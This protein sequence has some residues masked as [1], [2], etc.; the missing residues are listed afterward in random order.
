MHG[1]PCPPAARS[2]QP[3]G[4]P[5]V[6]PRIAHRASRTAPAALRAPY[7][8]PM[9]SNSEVASHLYE[10]AK[11][12][13]LA[14]GS[15]NAFRVRAYE[16]AAR[17]VDALTE[18]V[19][20][21]PEAALTALRGVG[22]S[23]AK[24]I[25][26]LVDTGAIGKLA[27]LRGQFPPE[28]V[29]LTRVPGV[30]PKT[31]V[32]LRDRLGITG[33]AALRV[34]LEVHALRDLPGFGAKTEE[35]LLNALD[36][37]GVGGKE[38]RTPIIDAM[39]VARDVCGALRGVPGVKLAEPM[40]SLRR[41]R[42]TTGD[43]DVVVISTGD[44]EAVMAR[45]VELPVVR[46]VVGHGARKSAVVTTSGLQVDL[47]VVEPHQYGSA[48]LYFTGS[49][50]H[51]IRLR[52]MAIDRG[53]ILNEYAL[54]EADGT[55]IASR[56]EQE[57][58][59]ALG[60]PWIPPELREDTGEIEAALA[61]ALP[62]L[63][64]EKELRGDLHVHTSLSGDGRD[65]LSAMVAAAAKRGYRYMAITDHAEDLS[66]NG[67][68]REQL[69]AQRRSISRLQPKHPDLAILQGVELNIGKDGS[70]DYDPEFLDGFGFG[71]ASVHSHF[72]LPAAQQTERVI[73]AMRNRAVNVIGHLT[74]RMIG[75]RP[76]IDLDVDAI[77]VAA[78]ETG[79]ALEVNSH[80][81]RLDAPT[82][83]LR[84]AHD[85]PGVIF[86]ISTDSHGVGEL[87]D[88]TWGVHHARRGW[89]EKA[90]VANTWPQKKFLKWVGEKRKA[91]GEGR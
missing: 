39:R 11:L 81:D 76:G 82:E 13:T 15:S 73:A 61:G 69:L 23:T 29:E 26:E 43:V 57:V 66:I 75:K 33:V 47:R 71:V 2:L 44:P 31:A 62:D 35:N 65:P 27:E 87:A 7:P 3:A 68:T 22:P 17:T 51:N 89:V 54:A 34:A 37:L 10:L 48:A 59:G 1:R 45:F 5:A 20:A 30:G 58:Y 41:F 78:E 88:T 8:G 79:C 52:Q 4:V 28:F 6:A 83:V 42:E 63:V 72:N 70:V 40:G 67:A 32:V 24:K 19:A 80:L 53:W 9:I 90:R 49:K 60:L 77:L 36:R 38:N 91:T 56:T 12:S 55:V 21:M 85:R 84:L 46:E 18:P 86:V 14:E 25:R 50:A 64:E 16:T 74:G